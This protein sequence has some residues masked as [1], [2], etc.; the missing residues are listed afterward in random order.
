MFALAFPML[1]MAAT[2]LVLLFCAHKVKAL[3]VANTYSISRE[4]ENGEGASIVFNTYVWDTPQSAFNRY[5]RLVKAVELRK[6]FCHNR[7]E[8]LLEENRNSQGA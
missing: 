4:V 7:F 1:C 2:L 6:E 8:R 5:Q 3:F